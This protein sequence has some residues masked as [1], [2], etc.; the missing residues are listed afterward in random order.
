[1]QGHLRGEPLTVTVETEC[2]HCASPIRFR[3]DGNLNV[4]VFALGASPRVF[5]P[6]VDLT[7]LEDPSIVDAF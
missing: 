4:H 3:L 7:K 6:L 1:V 5:V 2:A